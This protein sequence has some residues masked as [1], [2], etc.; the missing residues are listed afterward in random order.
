[1]KLPSAGRPCNLTLR[2]RKLLVE[3]LTDFMSYLATKQPRSIEVFNDLHNRKAELRKLRDR[4][5]TPA[6]RREFKD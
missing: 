5:A 6:Q 1:M 4:L 2:E 3:G